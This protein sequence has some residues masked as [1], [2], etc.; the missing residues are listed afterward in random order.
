[1]LL[2]P[3]SP[4]PPSP[5]PSSQSFPGEQ[6][7]SSVSSSVQNQASSRSR[8]SSTRAP[9]ATTATTSS[10]SVLMIGPSPASNSTTD[11]RP[12]LPTLPPV[13]LA[14][15]NPW[16]DIPNT[17]IGALWQAG[18][19]IPSGLCLFFALYKLAMFVRVQSFRANLA[20]IILWLVCLENLRAIPSSLP[21]SP[22]PSL[23]G[24]CFPRP[25]SRSLRRN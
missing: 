1:M 5:S 21:S 19:V 25:S 3:P 18:L 15:D 24:P 2:F 22:P 17:Y 13:H 6:S 11:V 20:Q 14:L 8:P 9:P 10:A 16:S 12:P 23:S 7:T 4:L